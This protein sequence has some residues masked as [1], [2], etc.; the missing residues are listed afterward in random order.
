VLTAGTDFRWVD[1]DSIAMRST[2][3]VRRKPY[4][5]RRRRAAIAGVFVQTF[6]RATN[7]TVTASPAD[8]WRNYDAHN[9]ETT[10]STAPST[11]VLPDKENSV[12]SPRIARCIAFTIG[13]GLGDIGS[14]FRAPTLNGVTT[15]L[16]GCGDAANPALGPERLTGGELA[17]TCAL[18][19]PWRTTWFDNR[20]KDPVAN[21]TITPPNLIQ[22][23][24]LGRTRSGAFRPTP[25]TASVGL[26]TAAPTSTTSRK[27][28][29]TGEPRP[30]RPDCGADHRGA[31]SCSAATRVAT[32]AF[33]L[34]L[35]EQFDDDLNTSSRG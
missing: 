11:T 27:W 32:I 10:L 29:R 35:G 28:S 17:S 33:D 2:R 12:G 31:F 22:R 4:T 24:N 5:G 13:C 25:T 1:G 20:V 14:G 26:G 18:S 6:V 16:A 19:R 23:Q 15:L 21:V 9:T 8:R 30:R 3:S 34:D 7:L